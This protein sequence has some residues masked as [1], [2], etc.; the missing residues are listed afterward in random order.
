MGTEAEGLERKPP[1]GANNTISYGLIL[2]LSKGAKTP[3]N[4]GARRTTAHFST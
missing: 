4:H 2:M 3:Q 1:L